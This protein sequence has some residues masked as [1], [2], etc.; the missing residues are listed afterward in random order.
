MVSAAHF[1][2]Q[3]S[4]NLCNLCSKSPKSIFCSNIWSLTPV[5]D[6]RCLTPWNFLSDK[7]VFCSNEVILCGL[8][9]G[10]WSQERSCHDSKLRIFS[11]TFHSP[12]RGKGL[13]MEV[14]IDYKPMWW[15]L[16][17]H[18]KS[19]GL[20]ELPGWWTHGGEAPA[21]STSLLYLSFPSQQD[22]RLYPLS[23]AFIENW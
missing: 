7:S 2:A 21:P 15:S 22:V 19:M 5:F 18:P 12:E 10:C 3:S 6:T 9:N 1:L 20:R 16:H 13:E 23:Y 11:S 4:P 14:M 17:K 8:L